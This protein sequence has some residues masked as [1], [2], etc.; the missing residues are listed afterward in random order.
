MKPGRSSALLVLTAFVLLIPAGCAKKDGLTDP[1]T[2]PTAEFS[3]SPQSGAVPLAVDFI[4]RSSPGASEITSTL[5]SFG[6]GASSTARNA[7]HLYG[8]SGTYTVS[9]TVTTAKGTDT[10]TKAGCIVAGSGQGPT[11]PNAAFTANKTAGQAPLTVQFTDQSTSGSSVISTWSWTFGDGASSSVKS[12]SHTYAAN[13][14]YDVSL[15]VTTTVGSD[16]ETKTGYIVVSTTT[17]SPTADFTGAPRQGTAPL[18]VQF[19]DAS[20]P[21]SA[22]IATWA[23]TFGDGGISPVRNPIHTYAAG[24]YNVTLTVTSTAGTDS[25]V[26]TGCIVVTQA[27]VAPTAQ[28]TAN[29]VAGPLPLTVQ[30]TDQSVAGTSPIT[31]RSWTFGDGGVSSAAN[32]SHLYMATGAYTVSLQVSSAAGQGNATKNSYIQV[33]LPNPCDTPVYSI[34]GTSWSNVTDRDGYG[35]RTS[36]RLTWNSTVTATCTKSVFARI[37]ARADSNATWSLIGESTCYSIIGTGSN[38]HNMVISGLD[39]A[40]YD[41]GI[42]LYECTGTVPVATREPSKDSDLTSQCFEP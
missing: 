12:P 1:R 34:T 20:T 6:D 21:G 27:S 40:C 9:L 25:Q 16:T 24:Q 18:D 10:K 33:Q 11:P 36:G 19:T 26:K 22:P 35:Y 3:A 7:S 5:W 15:T 14:T 37:Y 28:F 17:V 41:F 13:G 42:E 29:P 31:S 4:D 23:W 39:H 32:P 30:F 8:A 38:S 2:G